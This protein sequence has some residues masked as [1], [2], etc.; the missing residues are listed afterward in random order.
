MSLTFTDGYLIGS[1][2]TAIIN[3]IAFELY[4]RSQREWRKQLR[5]KRP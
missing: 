2:V 3:V 1:L 5:E 4:R